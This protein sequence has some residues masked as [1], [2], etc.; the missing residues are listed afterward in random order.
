MLS[1]SNPALKI[2]QALR[3][4]AHRF[5]ITYHKSLRHKLLEY[6]VLDE[7]QGIGEVRKKEILS[8][9]GSVARLKKMTPEELSQKIPHLGIKI[10]E[11]IIDF[12]QNKG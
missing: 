7:I 8:R 1:R 12:L 6:S 9:I 3:D 2:L 10:S 5:A 4:E 11:K